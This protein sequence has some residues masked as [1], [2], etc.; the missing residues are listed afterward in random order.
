MQL[1]YSAGQSVDARAGCT[2]TNHVLIQLRRG[3]VRVC[4][5]SQHRFPWHLQQ[6]LAGDSV[7]LSAA[8]RRSAATVTIA[9]AP[10]PSL[11]LA[12]AAAAVYWDL[13]NVTLPPANPDAALVA[14]RRVAAAVNVHFAVDITVFNM[15]ANAATV[16]RSEA[17][18]GAFAAAGATLIAVP[19]ARQAADV[20]LMS[21]A[22]EFCRHN[23][24][25]AK[26][27]RMPCDVSFKTGAMAC[28]KLWCATA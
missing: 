19:T 1:M 23:A 8:H 7:R 17:L 10:L 18:L 24:A 14:V 2:E 12:G 27:V 28:A 6:R 22:Y 25:S 20:R 4:G 26:E 21:E 11:Q 9:T 15:Y 16:G 13:D 5:M 3:L